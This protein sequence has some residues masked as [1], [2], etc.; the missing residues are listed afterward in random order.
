[1]LRRKQLIISVMIVLILATIAWVAGGNQQVK[2]E[3]V[4]AAAEYL[5][6]GTALTSKQLTWVDLPSHLVTADH[7]S[8]LSDVEDLWVSQTIYSGET[9]HQDRL[10]KQP[11]GLAYPNAGPNR[12]LMTIRLQPEQANG[13]W[14]TAGNKV[15]LY[16][17]PKNASLGSDVIKMNKIEIISV[18]GY[19]NLT[20]GQTDHD[21]IRTDA[22]VC[23]DLNAEQAEIL[24]SMIDFSHIR[25]T[26]I[27]ES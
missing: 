1:M 9:L 17:I 26:V 15:D 8:D 12:R 23:F 5:P 21:Y 22:L 6:A 24:S 11:G 27:N 10:A 2:T 4:L 16:L 3:Q 14:L 20:P 18:M 19:Q 7:L 13:F 25:L